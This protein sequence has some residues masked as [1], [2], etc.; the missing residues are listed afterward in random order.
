MQSFRLISLVLFLAACAPR[1]SNLDPGVLSAASFTRA[2]T[3]ALSDQWWQAFS[4]EQVD[5]F[6]VSALDSNFSLEATWHRLRAAKARVDRESAS[7]FPDL[8]GSA[9]GEIERSA[10]VGESLRLGLASDYELDLWGKIRSQV[11]AERFR[12]RASH[13]DYQAAALT[14]AAE[15][16]RTWYQLM[17]ARSRLDLFE[18]QIETN[19][20]VLGLIR[21][22]FGSGQVRSVDIM[23]QEQLLESTREQKIGAQSRVQVL[24]HQLAV[25]L[26]RPPQQMIAYVPTELPAPPPIPDTGLP[27]ALIQRRPDV[28]QSFNLLRAADRELA[29]AITNRYPRLTLSASTSS[30]NDGNGF[31]DW[32]RNITGGL[33]APIFNAGER[34]AEVRRTRALKDERL[35]RYGQTILTAFREVEDALVQEQKQSERIR[36]IETQVELAR[37]SYDQVRLEYL[38]GITDYLNVLTALTAE[39]RLRR[40]LISAKLVLLEHRIALYRALAG[41]FDTGRDTNLGIKLD[42]QQAG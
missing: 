35:Y 14:L 12:F 40:D 25:L 41:G 19:T 37:R 24:E 18:R 5:R 22:R 30:T 1:V 27:A 36:S 13:A 29:V 9:V 11:A 6:V 15:V 31:E 16:V 8:T 34:G 20:Q 3:E 38:N 7:F 4:D 17:D 26:G 32:A 23:R 10:S 39:Q 33:F 2:G 21:A 42:K 28:R